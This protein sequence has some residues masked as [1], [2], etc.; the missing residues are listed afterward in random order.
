[1]KGRREMGTNGLQSGTWNEVA[2]GQVNTHI[3]TLSGIIHVSAT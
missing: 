3:A 1:V 2:D